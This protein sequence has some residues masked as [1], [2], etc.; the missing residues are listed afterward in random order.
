MNILT[1]P[2]SRITKRFSYGDALTNLLSVGIP[3]TKSLPEKTILLLVRDLL[4]LG[5]SFKTSSKHNFELAPP[6]I[7][8]KDIVREGMSFARQEVITQNRSWIDA[9][10]ETVRRNLSSGIDALRSE[11][12]P[13]IEVCE[14]QRQNDLFRMCRYYWSSPASEYV[15]RRIRVLVR[16]GGLPEKPLIGIAAIGSSIIHIPDRDKW[17]G[18]DIKTR[19]ERII[20]LMDAYVVGALPPYSDLLGGKLI[21]YILA[22]NELRQIY[23]KKYAKT[24]TIINGRKRISD[25]ALIMT[26]SLYGLNSSQYNRLKYKKSLLCRPIG[27]TSGFG[28]I[29]ISN[30]TFSAMREL[31]LNEGY[32]ISHKFGDGPNWRMRVV[33]MACDL[34]KLDPDAILKHSFKRGLFAVPLAINWKGYLNGKVKKL[35]YRDLPLKKLTNHWQTRWLSMRKQNKEVVARVAKFVPEQFKI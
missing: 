26:T 28:T 22:S 13:E 24:K 1:V 25:L 16:D 15:G 20:Y 35:I 23:K 33:R 17:I 19:T 8:S 6:G 11:I 3:E 7:Y 4:R 30:E 27:T 31:V 12:R 9:H 21:A 2:N 10:I 34:L 5:W 29:H 32:D 14:T 18:W